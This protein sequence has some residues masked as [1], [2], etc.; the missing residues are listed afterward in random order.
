MEALNADPSS[1]NL[2]FDGSMGRGIFAC[3]MDNGKIVLGRRVKSADTVGRH[4]GQ[5]KPRSSGAND[6]KGGG[7]DCAE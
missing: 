3:G 7:G 5:P 6:M 2:N 4:T 1:A